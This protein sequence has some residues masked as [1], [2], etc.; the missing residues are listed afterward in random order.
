MPIPPRP[1]AEKV[2][3]GAP[4]TGMYLVSPHAQTTM[5]LTAP[6]TG[7]ENNTLSGDILKGTNKPHGQEGL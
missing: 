1:H 7:S 4:R 2:Y 6:L 3:H 5:P